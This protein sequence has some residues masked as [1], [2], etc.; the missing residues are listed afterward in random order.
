[1]TPCE[2]LVGNLMLKGKSNKEIANEL[3]ITEKTVKFHA[4][5]IFRECE[6]KTRYEYMAKVMQE[7]VTDD[8]L[9]RFKNILLE[10]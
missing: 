9:R 1:M 7:K 2:L 8:E 3:G 6:V 10:G 4:T 5:N